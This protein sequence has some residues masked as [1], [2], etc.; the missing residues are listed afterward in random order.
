MLKHANH[1]VIKSTGK[2]LTFF[3]IGHILHFWFT[4]YNF[5]SMASTAVSIKW[6]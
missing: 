2:Y 4:D 1:C 5:V 3:T 6:I